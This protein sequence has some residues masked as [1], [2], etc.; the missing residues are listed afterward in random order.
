ML[1]QSELRGPWVLRLACGHLVSIQTSPGG[2]RRCGLCG[3]KGKPVFAF[4]GNTPIAI[5]DLVEA[6][7]NANGYKEARKAKPAA[8]PREHHR[9]YRAALI[10]DG[11]TEADADRAT[12]E[13]RWSGLRRRAGDERYRRIRMRLDGHQAPSDASYKPTSVDSMLKGAARATGETAKAIRSGKTIT[14]WQYKE[15]TA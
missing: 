4:Y 12:M 15:R 9:D 8:P 1:T 11:W 6:R 3:H 14:D 13:Y 2:N 7:R 10:R 5:D